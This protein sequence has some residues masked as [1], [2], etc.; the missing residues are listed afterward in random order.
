[1]WVWNTENIV[2][3]VGTAKE[4]FFEFCENHKGSGDYAAPLFTQHP[5]NRVFFYAHGFIV[6]GPEEK[7]SLRS[8]LREAH[9]RGIAVDYADG[10][11]EWINKNAKDA[12]TVVN[13]LLAFNAAGTPDE[14]FDGVMLD[15]E[16]YTLRGWYTPALWNDYTNFLK[17]VRTKIDAS[18]SNLRMGLAIPR[19]YDVSLGMA[20]LKELYGIVNAVTV[21]DYVN[22]SKRLIEDVSNEIA[23][24][25]EMN[26]KVYVGVETAQNIISTV[27][28]K[29]LGWMQMEND[30][31]KVNGAYMFDKAY[32]G[33]AVS[34]YSS[35]ADMRRTPRSLEFTTMMAEATAPNAPELRGSA[36]EVVMIDSP[37]N[38]E[39]KKAEGEIKSLRISNSALRTVVAALPLVMTPQVYNQAAMYRVPAESN[40]VKG[41]GM[42]NSTAS[43]FN[44][45]WA[46][47]VPKTIKANAAQ[48]MKE[49]FDG[50][51]VDL[52]EAYAMAQHYEVPDAANKVVDL[53]SDMCA[54]VRSNAK[55]PNAVVIVRND[56]SFIH[57]LDDAHYQ[58]YMAL[59]DG[60]MLADG[61]TSASEY[62]HY[63]VKI[64]DN[65][66]NV[67][68][69][70]MAD[71]LS[72]A[73]QAK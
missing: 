37:A 44:P 2:Y 16:P 29:D 39:V 55:N 45:L 22:D 4:D 27:T 60:V 6:S 3:S 41:G 40:Y 35:Y 47:E 52:N 13:D 31:S 34:N 64:M 25:D 49:G 50:I 20:S 9:A 72:S 70:M 14:Q 43:Y 54:T 10:E 66:K 19:W 56:N 71:A 61:S 33:V 53:L 57:R 17:G 73:D 36:A 32:A 15:V 42:Q 68:K 63:G 65:V 11:P 8:F 18:H 59:I 28:Y 46:N 21:M 30:L 24:G 69:S 1:M 38:H 48:C 67:E 23:L 12:N 7:D 51:V 26:V 5:Y 62:Q 58:E